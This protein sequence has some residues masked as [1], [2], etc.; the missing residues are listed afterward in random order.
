MIIEFNEIWNLIWIYFLFW[1]NF[2]L[3]LKF[4]YFNL[5]NYT[6]GTNWRTEMYMEIGKNSLT[7]NKNTEL[8]SWAVEFKLKTLFLVL[9]LS[10][11]C[12]LFVLF[13]YIFL[14]VFFFGYCLYNNIMSQHCVS[15]NCDYD[16]SV[17]AQGLLLPGFL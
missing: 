9:C 10:F 17:S 2:W 8:I 4:L 11:C 6:F 7:M 12:L 16:C 13:C 3:V 14:L 5:R 1:F 15:V